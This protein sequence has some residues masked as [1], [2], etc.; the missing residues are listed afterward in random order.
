MGGFNNQ[1]EIISGSEL[2][3]RYNDSSPL[4]NY[5]CARAFEIAHGG[6][7]DCNIFDQFDGADYNIVRQRMI[8]AILSTDMKHHGEFIKCLSM[9]HLDNDMDGEQGQFLCEMLVHSADISNA[10]MAKD[11]FKVWNQR[12]GQEFTRQVE[13]ERRLGLPVTG[14]MD[15]LGDPIAHAKASLGFI[16]FVVRPFAD[17]MFSKFQGLDQAKQNLEANRSLIEDI[18]EEEQQIKRRRSPSKVDSSTTMLYKGVLWKLNSDGDPKN[19]I[20]WLKREMWIGSTGNLCYYSQKEGKNVVLLDAEYLEEATISRYDEAAMQNAFMVQR[21]RG[22][23]D[24][25]PVFACESNDDF[26]AWVSALKGRIYGTFQ[27]AETP[28]TFIKSDV[29]L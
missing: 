15:G 2:S 9:F 18:I 7:G 13:E 12:I 29:K 8:A 17:H 26:I 3:L 19:P 5:H 24:Y 25:L 16:D 11:I 6:E 10:M 23:D 4:E 21:S 14:Y 1:F 20:D 28:G 27:N 22:S